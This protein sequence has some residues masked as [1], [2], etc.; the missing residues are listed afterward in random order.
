[1][2]WVLLRGL[3]RESRHWLDFDKRLASAFG[4]Q[5]LCLDLPGVG[6]EAHAE[7]PI[8]ITRMTDYVRARFLE[9]RRVRESGTPPTNDSSGVDQEKWGVL[10]LSLGGTVALD[11]LKRYPKDFAG[12]VIANTSTQ[13]LSPISQRLSPFA[14]YCVGQA[15]L[16]K[17]RRQ[18]E[19][20]LLRA[21]SNLR[22]DDVS[23]LDRFVEIFETQPLPRSVF[24]R[25][26]LAASRFQC[27]TKLNLPVLILASNKDRMVDVRCSRAL[28]DRLD[29]PIKFH[30]TAGHDLVLDDEA[31]VID[32]LKE[33]TQSL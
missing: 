25:Q 3:G 13:D 12:G 15:A 30:P 26:M 24:V 7:A 10:A 31:W 2:N 33:F 21:V 20:H 6:S 19:K 22:A 18:A 14:M 17:D 9:R 27:P 29:A 8:S 11:W 16:L 23:V 4:G 28:A 5:V 1:M 32:R